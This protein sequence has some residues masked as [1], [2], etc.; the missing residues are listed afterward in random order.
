MAAESV[1]EHGQPGF[2]SEQKCG[3]ARPVSKFETAGS[4]VRNRGR[5]GGHYRFPAGGPLVVSRRSQSA[6][7]P[8]RVRRMTTNLEFRSAEGF[9]IGPVDFRR[10]GPDEV[11]ALQ[12]PGSLRL[13]LTAEPAKRHQPERESI[14]VG[15]L[16]PERPVLPHRANQA[17]G[18]D[19]AC[20]VHPTEK[21]CTAAVAPEP[22]TLWVRAC[23]APPTCR[24]PACPR[25]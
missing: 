15:P 8:R 13:E 3:R 20:H 17:R 14:F 25:S 21:R 2:L 12:S 23:S 18:K 11:E 24:A 10:E 7:K 22:P 5:V 4:I 1:T 16:D 19:R 6:P 9:S